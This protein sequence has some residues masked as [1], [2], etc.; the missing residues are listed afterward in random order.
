M[1]LFW[2]RRA[3]LYQ[4]CPAP[5]KFRDWGAHSSYFLQR[6]YWKMKV[7]KRKMPEA[8]AAPPMP[9]RDVLNSS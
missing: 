6:Q 3:V 5:A 9:R 7:K 8:S 2:F 1:I 4:Q